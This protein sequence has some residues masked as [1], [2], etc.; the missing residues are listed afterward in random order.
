[1][2][3]ATET[4]KKSSF[5]TKDLVYI[6]LFATLIAVCSW[7]SIPTT[8]PFTMQTFAIF[9]AVGLLGGKRGTFSVLVYILLGAL[10]LPVFAGF[11]GGI[12]VLFGPTGGYIVGFLFTALFMW[13]TEKAFAK[14]RFGYVVQMLIGLVICYLFGTLWFMF[15]YTQTTGAIG[16]TAVLGM[17]VIPFIIPDCIKI[18]LASVLVNR[19]QKSFQE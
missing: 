17:C 14:M 1:M 13:A 18:F 6:G 3:S 7:I 5:R 9:A 15:V 4:T 11:S 2:S 12:G 16:F 19:L 8:V 10:G